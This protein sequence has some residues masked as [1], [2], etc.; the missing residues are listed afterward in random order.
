MESSHVYILL[1][2]EVP[3][4]VWIG[5]AC[6]NQMATYD[7]YIAM[8]KMDNH[9]QALSIKERRVVVELM[10]DLEEISLDDNI[11]G[12]I[13]RVSMQ[14]DPIVCKELALFLKNNQ[15]VFA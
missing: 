14:A 8:L 2:C 3:N 15:N 12:W 13:T 7:C 6:G 10:E 4:G 1:T 9:L 11:L 5:E